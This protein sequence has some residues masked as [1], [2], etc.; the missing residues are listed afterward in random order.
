MNTPVRIMIAAAFLIGAT[1]ATLDLL[2]LKKGIYVPLGSA[3]KGA[4]NAEMVNYWGGKSSIGVAQAE[5]TIKHL[6]AKGKTYTV[7][8]ECV[9]IRSGESIGT[10]DRVLTITASTQ[11]RM[12][13]TTYRYCGPR[14]QF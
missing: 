9:D 3:C 13:G 8:D 11:F 12:D 1:G 10:S 2:P 7:K 4:S 6:A 5:C 14:V